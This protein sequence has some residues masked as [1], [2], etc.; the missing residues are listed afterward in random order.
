MER[1]GRCSVWQVTQFRRE[2]FCSTVPGTL[3]IHSAFVSCMERLDALRSFRS[4]FAP[5]C[6]PISI[7]GGLK[8]EPAPVA[9]GLSRAKPT[10]PIIVEYLPGSNFAGGKRQR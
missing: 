1:I 8:V 2:P 7:I 6:A 4:A 3:S 9:A 5:C 10:A